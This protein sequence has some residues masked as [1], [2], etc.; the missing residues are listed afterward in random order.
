LGDP[1]GGNRKTAA[2]VDKKEETDIFRTEMMRKKEESLEK[3]I[4]IQGNMPGGRTRGIPKM[5]WM[6]N[7]RTWTGLAMKK[8]LRLVENRQGWRNVLLNASNPGIEDG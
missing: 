1:Q 6:D 4:I 7:I 2:G 3:E 8:L 5:R